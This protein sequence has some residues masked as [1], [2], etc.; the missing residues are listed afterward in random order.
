MAC[1]AAAFVLQSTAMA[2]DGQRVKLRAEARDD[3]TDLR[4]KAI[5][6]ARFEDDGSKQKLKIRVWNGIP[7]ELLVV[8]VNGDYMETIMV[9]DSGNGRI[10]LRTDDMPRSVPELSDGDLLSVGPLS[11]TMEGRDDHP[12]DRIRLRGRFD[13]GAGLEIDAKYRSKMKSDGPRLRFKVSIEGADEGDFFDVAINDV[14]IGT[15]EVDEDGDGK[16]KLRAR[17][18]DTDSFPK[19]EEGDTVTVGDMSVTLER[20]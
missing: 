6:K 12:E 1:C 8:N 13:D 10:R 3:T 16:L 15:I 2:H 17:G 20:R 11:A 18:D 4:F 9:D 14:F 19:I 7:G 5:Y